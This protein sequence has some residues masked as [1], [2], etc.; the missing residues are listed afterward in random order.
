MQLDDIIFSFKAGKLSVG[1]VQEKIQALH[2]D[3][4]VVANKGRQSM[5]VP[6][7]QRNLDGPADQS[8]LQDDALTPFQKILLITDG[9][10]TDLLATYTG[11]VIKVAIVDQR[12]VI[13]ETYGILQCNPRSLLLQREVVLRGPDRKYIYAESVFVIDRLSQTVRKQLMETN[14]PI[15]LLWKEEKLE[16]HREILCYQKEINTAVATCLG[17]AAETPL[18]SRTYR[19][20]NNGLPLGVITEKFP[21]TNFRK[22]I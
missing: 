4:P 5:V 8:V 15:G 9:T 20:T 1:E 3:K 21:I 12:I 10:V 18:L 16:S 13:S 19:I 11:D 22:N 17:E 7:H 6:I 14:Q 2:P